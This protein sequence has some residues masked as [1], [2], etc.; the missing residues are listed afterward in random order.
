MNHF[1]EMNPNSKLWIYQANREL[2]PTEIEWIQTQLD[3][4]TADWAAHGNQLHAAAKTLENHFIV[5]AVD[6]TQA[7]ASG[8]SVDNSI[9]FIKDLGK[10]LNVDFFDRLKMITENQAG[11]KK[12]VSYKQLAETPADFVYNPLVNRLGDLDSKFKMQIDAFLNL[13]S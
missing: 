2:T 9:R 11:E 12:Y 13:V 4:Y 3:A 7:V 1:N 8:C 5:L 10:E 6:S